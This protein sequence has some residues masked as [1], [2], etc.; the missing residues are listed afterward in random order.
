MPGLV[1]ASGVPVHQRDQA[2]QRPDV[3]PALE[4]T[5][6]RLAREPGQHAQYR[7]VA[8]GGQQRA[9]M[10]ALVGQRQG[11]LAVSSCRIELA[12]GQCDST[13]TARQMPRLFALRPGECKIPWKGSR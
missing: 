8:L 9:E 5:T 11:V 7:E 2:V 4:R 12:T 6:G 3:F 10:V 1:L 13:L